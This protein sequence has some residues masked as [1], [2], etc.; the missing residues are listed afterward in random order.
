MDNLGQV[1]KLLLIHRYFQFRVK[2]Y[3]SNQIYLLLLS[4]L[5]A[6]FNQRSHKNI[7]GLRIS[8]KSKWYRTLKCSSQ[9]SSDLASSAVMSSMG[10]MGWSSGV[11]ISIT[12]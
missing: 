7:L 4:R 12:C 8:Q 6:R 11:I 5:L 9:C 1:V 2:R 10:S 3:E